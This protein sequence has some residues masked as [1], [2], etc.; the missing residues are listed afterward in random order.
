MPDRGRVHRFRDHAVAG[1]N[2]R[3]TRFVDEVPSS[4]VCA[5]CRMIPK[6]TVLLPC[7]H[8]LC[9]SCHAASSRDADGRCPL[10][11]EPFEASQC[12]AYDLFPRNASAFKVHCWNESHGCQFQGTVRDTLEHYENA[13]TFHSVECLRCGEGVLHRDLPA[14]YVAGCGAGVSSTRSENMSA[15]STALTLQDVNSSLEE[16]KALLRDPSHDQL[17]P[18]VQ[19]QMNELTEQVRN[20][21]SRL[22]DVIRDVGASVM[23]E[24]ARG[25]ASISCTLSPELTSLR[26]LVADEADASAPLPLGSEKML[27]LRKLEQF[28]NMSLGGPEHSL[29]TSEQCPRRVAVRCTSRS[30]DVRNLTSSLPSILADTYFTVAIWKSYVGHAHRI[31]VEIAFYGLLAGSHCLP[32][33]F[34]FMAL[35]KKQW[36]VRELPSID[37]SCE[38]MHNGGSWAHFHRAFWTESDSLQAGGFLQD[39]HM[40]LRLEFS[41]AENPPAGASNARRS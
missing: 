28:A 11:Q 18:V 38:C 40:E 19:S 13:C 17:L 41:H 32:P 5:L 27:I 16:L 14:H 2:W 26:D 3:A 33:H 9:E 30:V 31:R 23:A 4:R 22:A 7:S 6:R 12:S 37:S 1:V 20:Q 24:M 35:N 39:G 29:P 34:R 25:A 10:D 36:R 8:A 15:E 21:E